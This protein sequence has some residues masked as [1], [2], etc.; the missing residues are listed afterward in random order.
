M[1][2]VFF[3]H[4]WFFT[5]SHFVPCFPSLSTCLPFQPSTKNSFRFLHISFRLDKNTISNAENLIQYIIKA[6][7]AK[8]MC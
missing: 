1:A 6:R 4:L 8:Y 5:L 2:F 3:F 7:N